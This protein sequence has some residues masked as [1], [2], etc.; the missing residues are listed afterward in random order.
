MVAITKFKLIKDKS[1]MK[2]AIRVAQHLHV[3][4]CEQCNIYMKL[5]EECAFKNGDSRNTR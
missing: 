5:I 1:Q 3:E 2:K 4:K